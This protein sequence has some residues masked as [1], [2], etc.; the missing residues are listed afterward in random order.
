MYI[1]ASS[2]ENNVDLSRNSKII[3]LEIELLCDT[4][5]PLLGLYSKCMNTLQYRGTSTTVAA[6]FMIAK[7]WNHDVH[8]Q[9]NAKESVE[10][11]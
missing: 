5:I 7:I 6:L 2:V 9:I 10:Y 1:S 4:A 8:Y 3:N 11:Y